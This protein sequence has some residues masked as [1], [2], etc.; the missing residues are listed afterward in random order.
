MA[1]IHKIQ[2]KKKIAN[3]IKYKVKAH[4]KMMAKIHKIQDKGS[5]KNDGKNP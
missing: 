5:C 1:N 4:V 3:S 2:D